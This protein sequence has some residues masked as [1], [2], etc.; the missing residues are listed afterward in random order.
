MRGIVWAVLM[1]LP[2]LAL[3]ACGTQTV[4]PGGSDLPGAGS[5][6]EL[7]EGSGPEGQFA[8]VAGSSVT[9][10]I[11]DGEVGGRSACNLYSGTIERTDD[12]VR[13]SNLGGTDMACE[14]P[15]MT[16]ESAYLSALQA[17]DRIARDGESLL[18]TGPDV[19]L[20]FTEVPPLPKA[21]LVG[22]TWVLES[23]IEGDTVSSTTGDPATLRLDEDGTLTGSTGCRQLSGRYEIRGGEVDA[24]ELAADGDCPD[25]VWAQDDHVVDVLGDGFRVNIAGDQLTL[26][27]RGGRGLAYR[28]G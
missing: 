8:L 16:L 10:N 14:P 25:D 19:R 28:A 17:V 20:R 2:V 9:L 26:T 1:S 7:L 12:T 23:L 6:W 22:T 18:L 21:E 27:S 15:V 4:A 24:T 5:M 3:S 13:I 11:S